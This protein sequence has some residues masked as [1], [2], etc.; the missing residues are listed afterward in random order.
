MQKYN[1]QLTYESGET[2]EATGV[3]FTKVGVEE[4]NLSADLKKMLSGMKKAI[5]KVN[6]MAR[7]LSVNKI[8]V[9]IGVGGDAPHEELVAHTGFWKVEG[10]EV[11]PQS[12]FKVVSP[13][14]S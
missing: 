11:L 13:I 1:C 9:I 14:N 10:K 6:F 8:N 5:D 3:T 4:F 2:V 7:L 12:Y